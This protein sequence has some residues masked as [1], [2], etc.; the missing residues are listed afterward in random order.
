[1]GA[2]KHLYGELRVE[3][4][5]RGRVDR[6]GG[7]EYAAIF[8]DLVEGTGWEDCVMGV[9]RPYAPVYSPI[10]GVVASISVESGQ[11]VEEGDVVLSL[12]MMKMLMAVE[13]PLTGEIEVLVGMNTPVTENQLLAKVYP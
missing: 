12:E 1:M 6:A 8:N 10:N 5:C 7:D 11:R 3:L 13:A 2:T 9:K 4:L